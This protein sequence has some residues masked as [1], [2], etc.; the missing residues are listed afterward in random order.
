MSKKEKIKEFVR[1]V[2]KIVDPNLNV[3]YKLAYTTKPNEKYLFDVLE[4]DYLVFNL[5]ARFL[6][7][8]MKEIVITILGLFGEFYSSSLL[9]KNAHQISQLLKL[10]IK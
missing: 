3:I 5:G 8:S 1:A 4:G 2:Y 9:V 6:E 10:T 7:K